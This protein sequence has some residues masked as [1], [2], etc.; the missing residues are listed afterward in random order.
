MRLTSTILLV[1]MSSSSVCLAVRPARAQW[2][3]AGVPVATGSGWQGPV[4][5]CSDG[6]G[7]AIFG[8]KDG[9]AGS[10][11]YDVYSQRVDSRGNVLWTT[12]GVAVCSAPKAQYGPLVV[13]DGA[14]GAI[15]AWQDDRAGSGN[16]GVFLQRLAASGVPLWTSNGQPVASG[17]GSRQPVG[18]VSD[19]AGGAIVVWTELPNYPSSTIEVDLFVQRVAAS[20]SPAWPSGGVTIAQG[21]SFLV[22]TNVSSDGSGGAFV[23][24]RSLVN[25]TTRVFAQRI[26]ADGTILWGPDRTVVS[27][28]AGD[29]DYPGM[30]VDDAGGVVLAWVQYSG[31][32]PLGVYTQRFSA[33]GLLDWAP[34]GVRISADT[35]SVGVGKPAVVRMPQLGTAVTWTAGGR[36]LAQSLSD[37]GAPQ[38]MPGGAL[39]AS[40]ASGAMSLVR[41]G[42]ALLYSWGTRAQR[43]GFDGNPQWGAG[44]VTPYSGVTN[45]GNFG[46]LV[47]DG[48][49]GVLSSGE[50][51]RNSSTVADLYAQR[52]DASGQPATADVTTGPSAQAS[53]LRIQPNPT[54]G[55][56]DI[57]FT[58]T[59]ASPAVVE[60]MDI[61]GRRVAS[62]LGP[63]FLA[64]GRHT[65]R[66]DGRGSAGSA[67]SS[68]VYLVRLMTDQGTHT[69]KVLRIE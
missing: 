63:E 48:A 4:R 42:D 51:F 53:S 47:P 18:V 31:T 22:N 37:D 57:A 16:A 68:G 35:T 3:G 2:N 62:L 19:G 38:W 17:T 64:T 45:A 20:G 14:G 21:D 8:W 41:S 65:V 25:D 56:A 54:R 67:L 50:D 27:T 11:N 66:W 34:E 61:Q 13:S 49:G 12:N 52:L 6:A 69:S 24:W 15:L 30:A 40:P 28:L 44:G 39:I 55:A 5:G 9:R 43:T 36:C 7:G 60:V 46:T 58:L 29:Q 26:G 10:A 32:A 1:F 59:A 23:C 33:P